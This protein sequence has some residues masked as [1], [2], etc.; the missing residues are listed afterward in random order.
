[1]PYK[2]DHNT[3]MLQQCSKTLQYFLYS[4]QTKVQPSMPGILREHKSPAGGYCCKCGS[5]HKSHQI[6]GL[7]PL[8]SDVGA[9]P[10]TLQGRTSPAG[11]AASV[12]F[13]RLQSQFELAVLH[14]AFN[15]F[16]SP[17]CWCL[18]AIRKRSNFFN[19]SSGNQVTACTI[20]CIIISK[21]RQKCDAFC[22]R[23]I[24]TQ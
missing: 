17:S 5:I 3:K 6:N 9:L 21:Q 12:L 14:T 10:N 18:G 4:P 1:V 7:V 13:Q 24:Q 2:C 11:G 19:N 23:R 22:C 8:N 16:F 20:K 15:S